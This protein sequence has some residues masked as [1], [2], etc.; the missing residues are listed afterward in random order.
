MIGN[1]QL[2]AK[3]I[4]P[5]S[6]LL[7]VVESYKDIWQ[8]YIEVEV[9]VYDPEA[10]FPLEEKY[11]EGTLPYELTEKTYSQNMIWVRD[12]YTLIET[13]DLEGN[14]LHSYI[15]ETEINQFSQNLQTKRLFTDEDVRFPHFIFYTK[16]ISV[17][18]ERLSALGV[19]TDQV[20]IKQRDFSNV[21]QLGTET[22]N[23]LVDSN[24][25]KVLEINRQI[26]ISGRYYPSKITFAQW[27][28]KKDRIPG[29]TQFFIDSRLF[30]EIRIKN[31]QARGFYSKR[32][33]FLK[34][35]KSLIPVSKQ[36]S[37]DC[38]YSQ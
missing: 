23:I 8:M 27:A 20:K 26:Q 16:H 36:F 34:K 19:S 18:K 35:Y 5:E 28:K 14:P 2:F 9:K 25:F 4:E 6:L 13:F 32:R 1:G 24:S 30:K 11:D 31:Y 33:S 37:L 10:F 29:V 21:Y 22:E 3:L 17:L 7:Q 15:F 12:E 38:I